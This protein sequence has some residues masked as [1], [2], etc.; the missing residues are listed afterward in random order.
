M[1]FY[2][3]ILFT[4]MLAIIPIFMVSCAG[5]K[6]FAEHKLPEGQTAIAMEIICTH[7]FLAEYDRFAI[8]LEDGKEIL[9]KKLYPDTGGYAS[10]NLYR[11][12]PHKYVLNGNFDTWVVD[13][14]TKTITEGN[15]DFPKTEY[16]GIFA[17][18]ASESWQFYPSSKRKEKLLEGK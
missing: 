16:I 17:N 18:A 14:D 7:A 11:S 4:M 10:T 8:L 5:S 9:R 6:H 3:Y 1:K 15:P 13:L 12:S 2:K